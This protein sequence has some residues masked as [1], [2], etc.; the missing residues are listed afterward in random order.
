MWFRQALYDALYHQNTDRLVALL[1]SAEAQ[2]DPT[3]VGEALRIAVARGY[4]HIARA[5]LEAG[6]HPDTRN[7]EGQTLLMW[8][9][10]RGDICLVQEALRL[11][12]T[13]DARDRDGWTALFHAA[14]AQRVAV[15][16]ALLQS[17]AD[18]HIKDAYGNSAAGVARLRRVN[19]KLPLLGTTASVQYRTLRDT[20]TRAL[21]RRH[22]SSG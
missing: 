3:S 19:I 22:G 13:I 14:H 5:F 17:G 6:I 1:T 11:G 8:A 2:V 7:G 15:V 21:L 18:A 10:A 12:A 16:E 4:D 9:A 20:P